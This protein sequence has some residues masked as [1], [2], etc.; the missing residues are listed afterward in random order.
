MTQKKPTKNSFLLFTSKHIW[1]EICYVRCTTRCSWFSALKTK[2][3]ELT[4]NDLGSSLRFKGLVLLLRMYLACVMY[5]NMLRIKWEWLGQRLLPK[6]LFIVLAILALSSCCIWPQRVKHKVNHYG[7]YLP[8]YEMLIK[9][10]NYKH[11]F[12]NKIKSPELLIFLILGIL[13]KLH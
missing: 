8:Q 3:A 12:L 6:C 2:V 11:A 9:D 10:E 5:L 4:A 1:E 7:L 13:H